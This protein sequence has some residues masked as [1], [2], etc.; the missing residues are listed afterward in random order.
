M[1][2]SEFSSSVKQ[3]SA[4]ATELVRTRLEV[5]RMQ[6]NPH[7]LFNALNT[8][9]SLIAY[10]PSRAQDAVTRLASTLRY[11]L[12]SSQDELVTLAQEL[13]I[14]NDYLEL[15]SMRFD[16]RLSVELDIPSSVRGVRIPVMLLQTVVDVAAADVGVA[17]AGE[18][19]SCGS[20]NPPTPNTVIPI[21]PASP[22]A[23]STH[24]RWWCAP[25]PWRCSDDRRAP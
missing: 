6:L 17:T 4:L 25:S 23:P 5:L 8:V 7:F 20:C 21:S 11:T 1:S 13:E 24:R 12:N 3:A 16:E 2:A 15:E 18:I 19:G 22:S 10:D 14:V 9:R